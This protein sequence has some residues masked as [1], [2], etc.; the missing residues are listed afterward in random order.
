MAGGRPIRQAYRAVADILI[1]QFL[2][3]GPFVLFVACGRCRPYVVREAD[4]IDLCVTISRNNWISKV[5]N[6]IFYFSQAGTRVWATLMTC[7]VMYVTTTYY[8]F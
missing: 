3:V 7:H 5:E 6:V 8:Y 1:Y 4:T 2:F